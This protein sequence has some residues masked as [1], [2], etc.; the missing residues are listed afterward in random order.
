MRLHGLEAGFA[1]LDTIH[2]ALGWRRA[3]PLVARATELDVIEAAYAVDRPLQ[4]WLDGVVTS[5]EPLLDDGHGVWAVTY[6]ASSRRH[7][8][9]GVLSSTFARERAQQ[10]LELITAA[11]RLL[12]HSFVQR[13]F[14]ER[15]CGTMSDA[16][17][18]RS[19][20]LTPIF[21]KALQRWGSRDNIGVNA[22]DPTLHGC[23]LVVP[24]ST[25]R[26]GSP[27]FV[28]TWSRVAGHVAAGF[29]LHR[30]LS[31]ATDRGL[32]AADAVLEV[33]GTIAHAEGEAKKPEAQAVLRAAASAVDRARAKTLHSGDAS[34]ALD[35]WKPL[36]DATWT[37]YD[38]FD[39]D[40]RRYYV[41]RKN[42][43][44]RATPEL[45]RRE[46]QVLGFA[47][48]GHSNKLIAYELGLAASTV[49]SHLSSLAKKLGVESRVE[50]V[51]KARGLSSSGTD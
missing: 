37:L 31:R 8:D 43:S 35:T 15:T 46:R 42:E 36:I 41:V 50:L 21:S 29:R 22:Q 2:P 6:D 16:L 34:H 5:V 39:R 32:D 26:A 24:L 28:H 12:P 4:A 51:R 25:T 30:G 10:R 3:R 11:I 49:A 27:D 19:R 33:D 47:A 9:F 13:N 18:G 48:L 44:A 20:L 23:A 14:V 38:T 45:T 7:V 17:E 40:G 1:T